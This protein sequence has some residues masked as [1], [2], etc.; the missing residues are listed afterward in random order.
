[1]A[2]LK[3]TFVTK[4]EFC[5]CSMFYITPQRNVN[6]CSNKSV[7]QYLSLLGGLSQ[8]YSK[9]MVVK[10]LISPLFIPRKNNV[11]LTVHSHRCIAILLCPCGLGVQVLRTCARPSVD[12]VNSFVQGRISRPICSKLILHMMMYLYETSRNTKEPWPIFHGPLTSDFGQII[13]V[14]IC[15]QDRILSSTNG[16]KLIFHIRM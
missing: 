16:S 14:K 5:F 12:Q 13:K 2:Q 4:L 9:I 3:F 7:G 8:T 11:C 6:G 1:M 15:V 10:K